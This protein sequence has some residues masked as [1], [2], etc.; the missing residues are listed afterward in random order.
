MP[1]AAF[2]HP[3][4]ATKSLAAGASLQ[5]P[6]YRQ[7]QYF[8]AHLIR[9]TAPPDIVAGLRG[10]LLREGEKEEKMKAVREGETEE[11]GEGDMREEKRRGGSDFGPSQCWKQIDAASP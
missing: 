2:L 4:N 5:T 7:C 8:S 3:Q 1:P 6:L 11:R 10:L 9:L